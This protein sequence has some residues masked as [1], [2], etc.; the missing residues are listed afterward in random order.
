VPTAT[1]DLIREINGIERI[2]NLSK[3]EVS[4]I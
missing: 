3:K 1:V 4:D 2:K